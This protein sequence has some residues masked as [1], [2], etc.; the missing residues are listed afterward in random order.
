MPTSFRFPEE[1][2]G[3]LRDLMR[4]PYVLIKLPGGDVSPQ[5]YGFNWGWLDPPGK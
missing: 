4:G 1:S 5:K 2:C 3:N